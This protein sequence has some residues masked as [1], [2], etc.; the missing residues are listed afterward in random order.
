MIATEVEERSLL[1][2]RVVG[3]ELFR[4]S[5][6]LR[7]LL[8]YVADCTLHD[9]L[10]DVREQVIATRVFGRASD[11]DGGQDSIVRA[12]ARNLR[13]RLEAY[14][15]QEGKD[16]PITISMPK[17]AYLLIFERRQ[18]GVSTPKLANRAEVDFVDSGAVNPPVTISLPHSRL[19]NLCIFL[20]LF[21]VFALAFALHWRSVAAG[22]RESLHIQTPLLPFSALFGGG[23]NCLIVTSD[24]G[25]LQIS[26]LAHQQITLDDYIARTYPNLATT[27]PPDLIRNWNIYEF[28]DGREMAIAGQIMRTY[29]Q[30]AQHIDMRSGREVRLDEFKS[31]SVILIG[32]TI[33][34][35]W[36]QMYEGDLNFKTD[37]ASDGRIVFVNKSPKANE[38]VRF[39]TPDDISCH[40]TYA[41]VAFLPATASAGPVLSIAGTTAQA[42]QA[43]GE[44]VLDSNGLAR[45]LH[46]LGV[47]ANGQP[48]FFEV[49]LRMNNFVAGAMSPELA[50]WRTKRFSS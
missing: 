47:N 10:A 41:R 9:R 7:D 35:P 34:N 46:T 8:L 12:E 22:L 38:P 24:T 37:L 49:L 16:E 45:V 39:P 29:P 32:S 50:V 2:E 33:S 20:S 14:F 15:A 18:T 42:T 27:N 26:S 43:A 48:Q 4:K 23:R 30:F 6:R 5:P 19:R 1:V 13:R 25:F 40:R 21:T 11:F 44:F 3:S 36:G 17:G 28:T 31:H